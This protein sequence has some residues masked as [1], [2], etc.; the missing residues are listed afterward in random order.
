MLGMFDCCQD[1]IPGVYATLRTPGTNSRRNWQVLQQHQHSTLLV[2]KQQ[3][4]DCMSG[5]KLNM[6]LL[7]MKH[8]LGDDMSGH[9]LNM[10]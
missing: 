9:Y 8:H 6:A 5:H 10:A 1:Y 4:R 2:L 7:V 3:L